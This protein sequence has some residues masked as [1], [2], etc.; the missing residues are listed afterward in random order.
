MID[1]IKEKALDEDVPI[2]KDDG[3]VFLLHLI[4]ERKCRSILELGTAV[5]Y[6]SIS[7]AMLSEDI[8]IDTLEKNE[9]MYRQAIANIRAE[10]LEDRIKVHFTAIE[11]F[12]TDKKYDLIFVDAA[13]AQYMRYTEQFIDNLS[14]DGV[15]VY[16][17]MIFHGMVYDVE[18]IRNR[19][20]RSLVRKL[21]KFLDLMR[22]DE[23]F[24]IM[25]YEDV[26]DGLLVA[27]RRTE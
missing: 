17:N 12:R 24:D 14:P 1:K 13:K 4:E 8:V 26:G 2:I 10:G 6:S 18:G 22:N 25:F 19:N 7:M 20:T 16:D 9:D 15:F 23:R 3:L 27:S 21:I 11:D 5:G